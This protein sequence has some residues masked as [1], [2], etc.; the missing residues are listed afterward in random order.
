M[1]GLALTSHLWS[2]EAL[3]GPAMGLG[4][5]LIFTLRPLWCASR[6]SVSQMFRIQVDQKAQTQDRLFW[7]LAAAGAGAMQLV[8]IWIFMGGAML[9]VGFALT[10]AVL[11]C[12]FFFISRLLFALLKRLPKPSSPPVAHA[13]MKLCQP[14]ANSLS[15]VLCLGLGVSLLSGILLTENSLKQFFSSKLLERS[16]AFFFLGIQPNRL[17]DFYRITRQTDGVKEVRQSLPYWPR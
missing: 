8:L 5:A 2:P 3:C 4:T 6:V 1:T 7:G 16:P 13:V 12:E 15:L 11:A 9:L 14:G 17:K 10:A